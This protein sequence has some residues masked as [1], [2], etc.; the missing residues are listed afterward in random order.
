M[1]PCGFNGRGTYEQLCTAGQWA[2][3][4]NSVDNVAVRVGT[5][6]QAGTMACGLARRAA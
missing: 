4:A 6:V 5:A 3:S 1:T 2:D